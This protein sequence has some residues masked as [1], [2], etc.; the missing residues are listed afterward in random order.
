MHCYFD[1][2]WLSL[3]NWK[4]S[5]SVDTRNRLIMKLWTFVV[6]SHRGNCWMFLFIMD[7]ESFPRPDASAFPEVSSDDLLHLRKG[8]YRATAIQSQITLPFRGKE[9][10]TTPTCSDSPVHIHPLSNWIFCVLGATLARKGLEWIGVIW[11]KGN[12]NYSHS[13]QS[14][15]IIAWETDKKQVFLQ[16]SSMTFEDS[17]VHFCFQAAV[18]SIQFKPRQIP[19]CR[20]TQQ[21]ELWSTR[22]VQDTQE[23][24]GRTVCSQHHWGF[25]DQWTSLRTN[26]RRPQGTSRGSSGTT[27]HRFLPGSQ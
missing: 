12:T 11:A 25:A 16:L 19:P 6:K 26:Q 9:T 1:S 14:R 10:W 13:W 17:A 21:G 15:V 3:R 4:A 8:W 23:H 27:H 7:H 2:C 24:S 20:C 18:I 5:S 22:A